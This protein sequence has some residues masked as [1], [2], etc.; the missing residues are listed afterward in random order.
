MYR[1][2]VDSPLLEVLK[3]HVDMTLRTWFDGKHGS[4][5]QLMVELHDLKSFFLSKRF[6]IS[7]I[8]FL[9]YYNADYCL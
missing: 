3:K 7:I 2:A 4:T 5:V 1:Q 8:L 9:M 6:Y